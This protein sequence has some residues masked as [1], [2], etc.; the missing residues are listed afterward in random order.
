[1]GHFAL[2]QLA[3]TW[4]S[5]GHHRDKPLWTDGCPRSPGHDKEAAGCQIRGQMPRPGTPSWRVMQDS[6]MASDQPLQGG[7]DDEQSSPSVAALVVAGGIVAAATTTFGPAGAVAG[8]MLTPAA[9]VLVEKAAAEWRREGQRRAGVALNQ[10]A[11]DS[12]SSVEELLERITSEP[13]RLGLLAD[14]IEAARSR[15]CRQAVARIEPWRL[16]PVVAAVHFYAT[17]TDQLQRGRGWV[18]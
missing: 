11:R 1:M 16:G 12:G 3:T 4:G 9:A 2:R 6:L 18:P 14:T 8:A 5:P 7:S 15:S 10:A 17:P 13:S